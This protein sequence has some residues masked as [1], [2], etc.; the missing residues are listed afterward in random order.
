MREVFA[1]KPLLPFRCLPAALA[2]PW[3]RH[4]HLSSHRLMAT[5]PGDRRRASGSRCAW[6]AL[7]GPGLAQGS[8]WRKQ[9]RNY[10]QSPLEDRPARC[11]SFLRTVDPLWPRTVAKVDRESNLEP[12]DG[13]RR[14]APFALPG[15]TSAKC[16]EK[17]YLDAEFQGQPAPL[18]RVAGCLAEAQAWDFRRSRRSSRSAAD[19]RSVPAGPPLSLMRSAPI[20]PRPGT[21]APLQMTW[22]APWCTGNLFFHFAMWFHSCSTSMALHRSELLA[23][24]QKN[25]EMPNP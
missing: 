25:L 8:L 3:P 12:G 16:D 9:A 13:G 23:K 17:A 11:T 21:A 20:G 19:S 2:A 10:L 18:W 5:H 24:S 7:H 1:D 15:S 22:P 6:P 4:C 14:D